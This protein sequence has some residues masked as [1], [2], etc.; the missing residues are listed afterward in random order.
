MEDAEC[1]PGEEAAPL[2]LSVLIHFNTI[3]SMCSS[4]RSPPKP[5]TGPTRK[6]DVAAL[7]TLPECQVKHDPPPPGRRCRPQVCCVFQPSHLRVSLYLSRQAPYHMTSLAGG[8]GVSKCVHTC[9]TSLLSTSEHCVFY[10]CGSDC[11][12]TPPGFNRVTTPGLEHNIAWKISVITPQNETT[13]ICDWVVLNS[14][15]AAPCWA[16]AVSSCVYESVFILF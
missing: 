3:F 14:Y 6:S 10:L 1:F 12:D 7:P 9:S 11:L 4:R 13:V 5:Q 15:S 8:G 16:S 2:G